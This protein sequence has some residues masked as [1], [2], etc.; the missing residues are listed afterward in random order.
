MQCKRHIKFNSINY[1]Y[2]S[3]ESLL[4]VSMTKI[5]VLYSSEVVHLYPQNVF[6]V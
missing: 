5:P 3:P 2:E 6:T 4:T 1:S